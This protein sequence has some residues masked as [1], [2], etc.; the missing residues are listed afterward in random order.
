MGYYREQM[1]RLMQI[2]GLSPVTRFTY[3]YWMQRLLNHARRLPTAISLDDITRFQ[4]HLV[5]SG[6]SPSSLNQSSAAIRLFYTHILPSHLDVTRIRYHRRPKTLPQVLSVDEVSRLL[7]SAPTPREHVML[8]TIYS[9]GLRVSEA[10]RLRPADVDLT[11]N[12]IR[13]H[14]KGNKQRYVVLAHSLK[15]LLAAALTSAKAFI[16]QNPST[17]RPYNISAFQHA[18][19]RARLRAK[20]TKPVTLHSLRHS[21]ATHL[22]ESGTDLRRIQTL[23]GHESLKTTQ[24]YTHVSPVYLAATPSPLDQLPSMQ[25]PLPGIFPDPTPHHAPP[26]PHPVPLPPD[27]DR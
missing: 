1:N 21:F 23:L 18:F 9:G 15:P 12:L 7:A 13:I 10:R 16:F 11:R 19:H 17:N 14:G 2:E 3:I 24:L 22:L 8:A 4:S 25:H 27:P 6:F 5:D 20:I 26:P